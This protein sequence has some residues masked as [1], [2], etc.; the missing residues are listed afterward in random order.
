MSTS[1]AKGHAPLPDEDDGGLVADMQEYHRCGGPHG[2]DAA[3]H[4]EGG[5]GMKAAQHDQR[6]KKA[7][8]LMS[9]DL[10]E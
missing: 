5:I 3:K 9:R 1:R 7:R 8:P 6:L 2:D 4:L 10:D